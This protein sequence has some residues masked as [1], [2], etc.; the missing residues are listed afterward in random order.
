VGRAE[1][2]S[3]VSASI[4]SVPLCFSLGNELLL[5]CLLLGSL[6][7]SF[8]PSFPHG[9]PVSQEKIGPLRGL[10]SQESRR[11]G[12]LS[13]FSARSLHMNNLE[14]IFMVQT[15][16]PILAVDGQWGSSELLCCCSLQGSYL[17]LIP[18][19]ALRRPVLGIHICI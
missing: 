1:W 8:L 16:I 6:L 9:F 7:I 12:L 2:R 18:V 13:C 5:L 11:C 19:R 4:H 3:L 17:M 14:P 10:Y 15:E